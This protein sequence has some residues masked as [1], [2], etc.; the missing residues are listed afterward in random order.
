MPP[1]KTRR[2]G[3]RC[4]YSHMDSFS[5]ND[6]GDSTMN[7][8]IGVGSSGDSNSNALILSL[9]LIDSVDDILLPDDNCKQNSIDNTSSIENI[10]K[11]ARLYQRLSQACKIANDILLNSATTSST[12][13]QDVHNKQPNTKSCR[14]NHHPW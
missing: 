12:L 14:N 5:T 3:E 13:T 10:K 7:N 4:C 1:T 6:I 2:V 8:S 11:R 9:Y